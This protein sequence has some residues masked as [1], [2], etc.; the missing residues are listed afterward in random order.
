MS[1]MDHVR[2]AF[3]Q[4]LL[5]QIILPAGLLQVPWVRHRE[6]TAGERFDSWLNF[7]YEIQIIRYSSRFRRT[8]L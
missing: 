6:L 8:A 7:T 1:Q 4:S 3:T 5:K 2:R